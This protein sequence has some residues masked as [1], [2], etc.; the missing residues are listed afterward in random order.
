VRRFPDTAPTPLTKKIVEGGDLARFLGLAAD[1]PE[2]DLWPAAVAG[3]LHDDSGAPLTWKTLDVISREEVTAVH[4]GG[5]ATAVIFR[6]SF[7]EALIPWLS[8]A[9]GRAV[10]RWSYGFDEALIERERPMVVI[11]QFVERK[12]TTIG[13]DGVPLAGP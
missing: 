3:V 8:Q 9:F 13:P 5:G 4:P 2:E 12:L 11:Q 6:D 10:W 1:L 7:G